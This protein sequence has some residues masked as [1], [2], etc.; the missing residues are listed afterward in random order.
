MAAR[1]SSCML[2][3]SLACNACW[4][5]DKPITSTESEPLAAFAVVPAPST[6]YTSGSARMASTAP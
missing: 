6:T 3:R 1:A 4:T 5:I 2:P